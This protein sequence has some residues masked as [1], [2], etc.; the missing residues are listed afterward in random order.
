[1][2]EDRF[3]P[4]CESDRDLSRGEWER[5]RLRD[6]ELWRGLFLERERLW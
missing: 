1:M 3:L 5:E 2:E 6:L 4:E